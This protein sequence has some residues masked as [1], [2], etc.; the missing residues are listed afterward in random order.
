[1]KVNNSV[2][3]LIIIPSCF[4]NPYRLKTS[5]KAHLALLMVAFLYGGNYSFAKE[6]MTQGN[7]H[8]LGLTCMRIGLGCLFFTLVHIIWVREKVDKKD[9]KT[10]ALCALMGVSLNQAFFLLGLN[11]TTPINGSL[12][13]AMTPIVVL[14]VAFVLIKEKITSRKLIG[15]FLGFV[16]TSVLIA[17]G[18]KINISGNQSLGDL[19]ILVNVFCFGTFL[20]LSKSLMSK[21]HEFTVV[22]W[23]FTIGI[24]FFLPFS[25]QHVTDIEWTGFS[26][27]TWFSFGYVIIG[28]TFGTYLLNMYGV[29]RLGP[30]MVSMYI[31]VQPFA[32]TLI[33]TS[34][35]KDKLT[36]LKIFCGA[37]IF[38]GV[39]FVTSSKKVS[40]Q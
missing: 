10:F 36:P 8:P 15:I 9:W 5:Y 13:V 33:A 3:E 27:F 22:R 29:K 37:L 26:S 31:Y 14:T 6:V 28:A 2:R 23:I 24:F 1:M 38:I 12:I 17:Y 18:Q 25:F 19:L 16:G 20:V 21:Y 35:G 39:Y 30:T 7:V 4:H 40:T 32:T 11:F 34:L